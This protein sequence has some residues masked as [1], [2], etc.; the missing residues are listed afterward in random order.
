MQ[1]AA[2]FK[3]FFSLVYCF[4]MCCSTFIYI[5]SRHLAVLAGEHKSSWPQWHHGSENSWFGT[6]LR[7]FLPGKFV[8][9]VGK[10][11]DS[12]AKTEPVYRKLSWSYGPGP[13]AEVLHCCDGGD[14]SKFFFLS[15]QESLSNLICSDWI[16]LFFLWKLWDE[17]QRRGEISS[18]TKVWH[19]LANP[20][21]TKMLHQF[22]VI[23]QG[24]L[25]AA[26]SGGSRRLIRRP[27][28]QIIELLCESTRR[29]SDEIFS[30]TFFLWP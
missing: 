19:S 10:E 4:S 20:I 16:E 23:S 30:C 17:W 1:R 6:S 29:G 5:S 15:S 24:N 3:V 18:R 26:L 2:L 8:M 7:I 9:T 11:K 14:H 12:A 28:V 13:G 22:N 27:V 25:Q 21:S